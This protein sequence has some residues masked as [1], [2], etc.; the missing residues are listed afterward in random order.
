MIKLSAFG[1]LW[2]V[3]D[4]S[5]FV[6]KTEVQLKMA[7]LAYEKFQARPPEAPKNKLPFIDDDGTRIGDSTFIRD[8]IQWKHGIDLDTGLSPRQRALAWTVERVVEDHL[9]WAIVYFR[10]A[11]PENFDKGPAI[12][13]T[14]APDEVREGA[15][16]NMAGVLRA[17]GF[18]R[19]SAEEVAD[20]AGRSVEALAEIVGDGPYLSGELICGAD[21]TLFAGLAAALSPHFDTPLRA[22]IAREPNLVAYRDRMMARF[23]PDLAKADLAEA[24][25]G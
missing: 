21:A 24:A 14:G 16:S 1:P 17:Q 5:P 13:F 15:R 7:G 6:I 11:V 22:A 9:Y 19:H 20:L 8:H 4:P 25:A 18:G 23:Y 10:W 3:P 12:F 2:G